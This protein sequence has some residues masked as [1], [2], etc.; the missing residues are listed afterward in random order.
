MS[1]KPLFSM[2]MEKHDKKHDKKLDK[3]AKTC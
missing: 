3:Q 2:I 1:Y